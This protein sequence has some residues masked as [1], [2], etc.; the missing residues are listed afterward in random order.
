M[1]VEQFSRLR[2]NTTL[3]D[4]SEKVP[5]SGHAGSGHAIPTVQM[6]DLS[7]LPYNAYSA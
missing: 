7:V 4:L 5:S 3:I 1:T 6:W 2:N